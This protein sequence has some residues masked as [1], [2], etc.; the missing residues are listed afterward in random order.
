MQHHSYGNVM[1]KACVLIACMEFVN[2]DAA[3]FDRFS[4]EKDHIWANIQRSAGKVPLYLHE[5]VA[6]AKRLPCAIS[7]NH[8]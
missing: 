4:Q 2:Q 6:K 8:P 5:E 7:V 1:R 3:E